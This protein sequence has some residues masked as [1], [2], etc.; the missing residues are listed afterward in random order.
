MKSLK[1]HTE[2]KKICKSIFEVIIG[3]SNPPPHRHSW[4]PLPAVHGT[5]E[6]QPFPGGLLCM[7]PCVCVC[8]CARVS[9]CGHLLSVYHCGGY[10]SSRSVCKYTSMCAVICTWGWVSPPSLSACGCQHFRLYEWMMWTIGQE[11]HFSPIGGLERPAATWSSTFY[12]RWE[13]KLTDDPME[14]KAALVEVSWG[15]SWSICWEQL[16]T[17]G[18]HC[19]ARRQ[20]GNQSKRA[21]LCLARPELSSSPP[22]GWPGQGWSRASW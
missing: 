1:N 14:M 4:V 13:T 9:T 5:E 16:Q 11:C 12:R 21:H 10:I 3:V 22:P 2:V 7:W 18:R 6:A 8:V 19:D 15:S 17:R 20:A